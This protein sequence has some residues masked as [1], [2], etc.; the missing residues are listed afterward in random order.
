MP[1]PSSVYYSFEGLPAG[2]FTFG[3]ATSAAMMGL[4]FT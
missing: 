2:G 4:K 1:A 3:G